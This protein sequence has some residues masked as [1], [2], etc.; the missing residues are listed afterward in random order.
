MFLSL[1]DQDDIKKLN[2]EIE[3]KMDYTDIKISD[4]KLLN[5]NRE[6]YDIAVM[7]KMMRNKQTVVLVR[8]G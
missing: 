2:G 5:K 7:L 6:S 4:K 3:K 8:R 1:K